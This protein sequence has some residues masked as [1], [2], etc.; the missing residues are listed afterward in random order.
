MG[1]HRGSKAERR[2]G[3][4]NGGSAT[5]ARM[6]TCGGGLQYRLRDAVP[7]R[8][9]PR[10]VDES[11]TL[12][13]RSADRHRLCS[14]L[15]LTLAAALLPGSAALAATGYTFETMRSRARPRPVPAD[16]FGDFLDVTLDEANRVGLRRAAL[17]GL[18]QRRGLGGSGDGRSPCCAPATATR[19][20]S[21][22]AGNFLAFGAFTRL[23]GSGRAAY[24]APPDRQRRWPL[25]RHGRHRLRMIAE[26]NAAPTPPGGTLA[27]A[28]SSLGF[29][30]MSTA[31]DVAFRSNVTGGTSSQGSSCAPRAARSLCGRALARASSG[32]RRRSRAST[33][34]R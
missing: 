29:F 7:V 2:A 27:A 15:A 12:N 28:I 14:Q 33:I 20:G 23:D 22:R 21:L 10:A 25:P 8:S 24:G 26:G 13:G 9:P 31:G 16:S 34:R 3:V 19:P 4:E 11:P 17:L 5:R 18:P 30:G 32:G 1:L 6:P